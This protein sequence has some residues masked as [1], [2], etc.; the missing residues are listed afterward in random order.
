MS[1]WTL[2]EIVDAVGV[3]MDWKNMPVGS[4]HT[5]SREV[6]AGGLFVALKGETQHGNDFVPDALRRGAGVV[7][8]D[9][10]I[11]GLPVP[12]VV[13]PDTYEAFCKLAKAARGRF[14]GPVVAITGSA[15]KTTTKEL[16]A[17][18]LQAH[19]PVGSFNNHVGVPLTLCRLSRDAKAYVAEIGMNHTGEIAPLAR[20]VRPQVAVVTNVFP[21]HVEGVGSVEGIRVEK[22]SIAEGLAAAGTLVVPEG[23]SLEGVRTDINIVR[24]NPAAPLPVAMVEPTPARVACANAAL[25]AV[26]VLGMETPEVLARLAAAPVAVGRGTVEVLGGIT[27]IDDSYNANPASMAAALEALRARPCT[28]RRLAILGDMKELGVESVG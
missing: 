1:L 25:A 12:N 17:G 28:G 11:E 22:L 10:V 21:V 15:G 26:R 6:A 16:M 20:M 14:T 9:R 3:G 13:V 2:G 24:F 19:A 8:S 7:V 27:L 4:V 23:L 18:M 5:D